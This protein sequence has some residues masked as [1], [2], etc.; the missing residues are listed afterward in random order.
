M[1]YLY[2]TLVSV[3][4]LGL[5]PRVGAIPSVWGVWSWEISEPVHVIVMPDGGGSLLSDAVTSSGS[6]V[7]ATIRVQLWIDGNDDPQLPPDPEVVPN[8]P[9]EDLWLEVPGMSACLGGTI[10]DDDTD[11]EGWFTFSASP[12]MGGANDPGDEESYPFVMVS[13]AALA[14]EYGRLIRPSLVFNSPDLNADRFVNLTDVQ[15]FAEDF[16]GQYNFRGDFIWDGIINLSDVVPLAVS[17]G[18]SCDGP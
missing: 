17:Q 12:A 2:F 18:S 5:S 4:A 11:A 7:D 15:L 9:R 16:W 10:A 3:M 13:G 6:L 1:R 14:D 8:F